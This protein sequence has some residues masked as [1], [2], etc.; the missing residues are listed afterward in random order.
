M[1]NFGPRIGF[2]YQVTPKLVIRSGYGMFYGG[3]GYSS[4]LDHL[5]TNNFPFLF[6]FNFVEPDPA[7]PIRP[8]NSIGL[9]ENGLVNVPLTAANVTLAQ[10]FNSIG[11][12]YRNPISYTQGTNFSAQYQLTPNQT[13]QLAY[14]GSFGRHLDIQAGANNVSE[15]LP[16]LLNPLNYASFPDFSLGFTYTTSQGSSYYN[17]LQFTYERHF[18]GGLYLLGDYTWSKCRSDAY[19][20]L[21]SVTSY[22]ASEIPGFGVP[23][24]YGL[25]D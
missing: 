6:N 15:M 7:H 16:P 17:S 25:C 21:E 3:L 13:L 9:I 12:E 18:S 22:R 24:D 14:V 2:A 8:S 1:D 19:D 23:G 5:G 4:G 20:M 10:G 11:R